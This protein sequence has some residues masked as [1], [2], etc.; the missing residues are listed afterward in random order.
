M[1]KTLSE[2]LNDDLYNLSQSDFGESV[3]HQAKRCLLDYLGVAFVGSQILEEKGNELLRCFGDSNGSA[4]VIGFDRKAGVGNAA[5]LNGLSAHVAELDDGVRF[6]MIHPG[7]PIISALLPIAEQEKAT[8]TDL[9][10]GII[11]GYEAAVRIAVAIQP[12]HY[13]CGHH[14][15]GTCGT[16]GAAIGIAAML[17]FSRSRMKDTLSSA[18][19]SASGTLKVIE[20]VSELKPLNAAQAA[21]SGLL[22]ASMAKAGFKGPYDVLSGDTGF[23]AMM[24]NQY[25]LAQLDRK[26]ADP[27]AIEKVYIKPY[28]SCRH[29]HAAI[30]AALRIRQRSDFRINE[31]Q[32]VKVIT[33]QGVLGKHDHSK[34]CG[35]SSAKMSIPYSVAVA[36]ASGKA[37]IEEFTE[38]YVNNSDILSLTKKVSVCSDDEITALVPQKRAAIVEI[39]ACDGMHHVERI[40]YPK[41]EPEN[42]LSD[43]E[44][45]ERFIVLA[46]YGNRLEGESN[47]IIQIVWDLEENLPSLFPLL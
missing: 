25:D 11:V 8:G 36:L 41:G 40:E 18:A 28:A 9:L 45:M 37:G 19:V 43:E 23:F 29:T 32:A 33:Y 3:V 5:F 47:E 24:S 6:G 20:D 14:P 30:E 10:A 35:V 46:G 42:P 34:I 17:G 2:K 15:T 26:H 1:N 31:I 7:S 16:I 38:K 39:T 12:S 44:L 13:N 27:L 21:V 22:A 4:T